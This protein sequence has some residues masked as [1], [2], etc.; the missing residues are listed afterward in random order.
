MRIWSLHPRHLDAKGL[1]ACWR[2]TLLAQ[3]VLAGRTKGYQH[4][5]Q[6]TRFRAAAD[7]LASVGAYLSGVA[8]EATARGY[9]FDRSRIDHDAEGSASMLVTQGQLDYEWEHLMAKLTQRSPADAER[10][11]DAV[12]Q[13]HPLFRVVPGPI[14]PW[15]RA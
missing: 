9:R 13:P 1:V 10:W 15:E 3:A 6:L 8:D 2:E 14:E 4:H 5:P 7:P 12:P 11:R